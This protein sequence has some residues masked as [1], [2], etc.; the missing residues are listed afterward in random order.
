[1]SDWPVF[2]TRRSERVAV[3]KFLLAALL[4]TVGCTVIGVVLMFLGGAFGATTELGGA[5]YVVG[6]LMLYAFVYSW[7]GFFPGIPMAILAVRKG[8]AGWGIAVEVGLLSGL[9]VG[10]FIGA[11]LPSVFIGG[12][13]A[14]LFWISLRWLAPKAIRA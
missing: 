3:W 12:V 2:R 13:M 14:A 6:V 9:V 7:I 5:L 8:F 11:L 4:S 1:M 10:L